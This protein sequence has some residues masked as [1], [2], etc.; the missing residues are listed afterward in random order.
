M[1]VPGM[2][3]I[4]GIAFSD[5]PEFNDIVLENAQK[6]DYQVVGIF[7]DVIKG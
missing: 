1:R 4:A 6:S 2:L 5:N 3:G 7:I